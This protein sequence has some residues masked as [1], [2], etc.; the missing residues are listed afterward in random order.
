MKVQA[1]ARVDST[2]LNNSYFGENQNGV[3]KYFETTYIYSEDLSLVYSLL[4]WG[5]DYEIA[6]QRVVYFADQNSADFVTGTIPQDGSGMK[7]DGDGNTAPNVVDTYSEASF[8][9]VGYWLNELNKMA[10]VL[11]FLERFDRKFAEP[12][13]VTDPSLDNE[14]NEKAGRYNAYADKNSLPKY[15][16]FNIDT[17]PELRL[18]FRPSI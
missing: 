14:C 16:Y 4:S 13:A 7:T 9:F 17:E 8:E 11:I 2:E 3:N 12:S 15:E 6:G 10:S 1:G 5:M 18:T